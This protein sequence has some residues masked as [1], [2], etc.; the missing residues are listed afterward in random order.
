MVDTPEEAVTDTEVVALTTNSQ[1]PVV[2]GDAIPEGCHVGSVQGAEVDDR[3][4]ERASLVV[5]IF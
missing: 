5:V 2:P 1:T 4:V 3:L